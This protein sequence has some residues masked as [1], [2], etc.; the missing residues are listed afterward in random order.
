MF[1]LVVIITVML[2]AGLDEVLKKLTQ[3]IYLLDKDN[4]CKH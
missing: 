2:F 3:I 4:T 1:Y